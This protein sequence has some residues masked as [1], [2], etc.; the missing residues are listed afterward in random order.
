MSLILFL[1]PGTLLL[2]ILGVAYLIHEGRLDPPPPDPP[3][4]EPDVYRITIEKLDK[5]DKDDKD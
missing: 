4:D 5:D 3:E 2:I 1:L